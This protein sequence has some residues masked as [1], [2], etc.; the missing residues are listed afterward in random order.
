MPSEAKSPTVRT[1]VYARSAPTARA[2]PRSMTRCGRPCTCFRGWSIAAPAAAASPRSGATTWP[3]CGS[4]SWHP[5]WSRSSSRQ[6]ACRRAAVFELAG[7]WPPVPVPAGSAASRSRHQPLL[8]AV[9]ASPGRAGLMWQRLELPLR[10]GDAGSWFEV[11]SGQPA[12]PIWADISPA[13]RRRRSRMPSSIC[14]IAARGSPR[15]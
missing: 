12:E 11:E 9:S 13:L 2:T 15:A 14:C 8:D 6:P 10:A 5:R 4:V 3:G 1:A 7:P